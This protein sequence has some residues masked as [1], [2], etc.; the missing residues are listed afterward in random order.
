MVN[1]TINQVVLLKVYSET[2][3]QA[4]QLGEADLCH[5]EKWGALC[6]PLRTP[7]SSLWEGVHVSSSYIRKWGAS[8][9]ELI[10]GPALH[11][12]WR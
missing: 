6:N 2:A 7:S 9:N 5:S 8:F 4:S 11:S 3:G 10:L 12:E 1:S